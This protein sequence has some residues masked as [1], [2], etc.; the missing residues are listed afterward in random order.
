MIVE[1]GSKPLQVSGTILSIL[2]D[3]NNDLLS[4]FGFVTLPTT[5]I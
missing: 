1:R 2:A 4:F 5:V 3:L